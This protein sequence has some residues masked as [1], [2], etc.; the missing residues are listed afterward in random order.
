MNLNDRLV[1]VTLSDCTEHDARCV[2]TQLGVADADRAPVHA[3]PARSVRRPTVWTSEIDADS[4]PTGAPGARSG[5]F[6]GPLDGA[7]EV[8]AQGSPHHVAM[9]RT[10]L[11]RAFTVED[12]GSVSGDQECDCLFRLTAV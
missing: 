3:A 9:L 7:V 4:G 12:E 5:S 2:L 10:T 11:A 1:T 6:T 8:T